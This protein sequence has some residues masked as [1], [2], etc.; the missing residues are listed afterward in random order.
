MDIYENYV[1]FKGYTLNY[2]KPVKVRKV[3]RKHEIYTK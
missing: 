3:T 1:D 2:Y